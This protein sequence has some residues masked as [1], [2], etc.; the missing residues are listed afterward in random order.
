MKITHV[1]ATPLDMPMHRAPYTTDTAGSKVHWEGRKSRI[2]PKRP[3]PVLSYVL[4]HI[5]TD[6]G[7][8]GI[9]EAQA[10]IGFFGETLESVQSGIEDYLGPQLIGRDPFDREYL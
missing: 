2:T 9:G 8:T 10:D 7:V 5:H 3:V 6:D 1:T 4:V